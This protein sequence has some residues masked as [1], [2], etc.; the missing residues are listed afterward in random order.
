MGRG[1]EELRPLKLTQD[2]HNSIWPWK[3]SE[4]ERDVVLMPSGMEGRI[5][6]YFRYWSGRTDKMSKG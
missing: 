1:G 2:L 6:N 4:L 3:A 5:G